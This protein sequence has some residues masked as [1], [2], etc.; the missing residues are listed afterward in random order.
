VRSRSRGVLFV[1]GWRGGRV[2][3][4]NRDCGVVALMSAMDTRDFAN[5]LQAASITVAALS[6]VYGINA[7]R[8][9]AQSRRI[10]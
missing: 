1:S 8:R 3:W 7:W 9:P 4:Y 6:A 10:A 5:L 2:D